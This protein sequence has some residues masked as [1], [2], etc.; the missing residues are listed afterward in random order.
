MALVAILATIVALLALAPSALAQSP[1]GETEVV[2]V[3]EAIEGGTT[4]IVNGLRINAA[5]AEFYTA[6]RVG[7]LVRVEGVL[8][9]DGTL[10]AR[11]VK[12]PEDDDLLEGYSEFSGVLTSLSATSAVVNGIVF[13][14]SGA[15]VEPGL[16]LGMMVRV[17]ALLSEGGVWVAREIERDDSDDSDSC[18]FEITVRSANLRSGPGTEYPVI[19]YAFEDDE[20][21]VLATDAS[22]T[23][24][25]VATKVGAA[26]VAL[27]VGEL[28]DDC[29]GLAITDDLFED[30]DS[31]RDGHDD[32]DDG[33]DDSGR[34][35]HDDSDDGDDDSGR[36]GHDDSDD[37]DDDSGRGGD[38]DSDHDDDDSGRDGDDDSDDEDED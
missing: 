37:D 36:S 25:Q 34:S 33:D 20:F 1:A 30:D 2:G 7:A 12:P 13:D 26:W 31:G 21:H 5:G 18:E 4:F 16:A 19:G 9:P 8:Q 38:D 14:I 10:L 11:E 35:G 23:W 29:A 32:S 6:I 15:E 3:I 22:Q 17:H 24:L 28:E 27:S